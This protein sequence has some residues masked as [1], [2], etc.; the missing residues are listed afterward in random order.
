MVLAVNDLF[1]CDMG[2]SDTA[3]HADAKPDALLNCGLG[4]GVNTYTLRGQTSMK[5]YIARINGQG[6]TGRISRYYSNRDSAVQSIIDRNLQLPD[7][8]DGE[9]ATVVDGD[10]HI[11]VQVKS[12]TLHD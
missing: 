10:K 11:D 8:W 3:P 9:K 4:I 12:V 2:T 6:Q 7:N 5:L 1:A